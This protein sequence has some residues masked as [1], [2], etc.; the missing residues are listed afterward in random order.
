MVR[1]VEHRS[2]IASVLHGARKSVGLS[3]EQASRDAGIPI[4]YARLLEGESGA[5]I[6]ISDSLY[7]IPFF[8]R[9]ANYLGL[10]AEDLLPDFLGEMQ[11]V[12][13]AMGRPAR[14][15]HRSPVALLWKP[16]TIAAAVALSVLLINRQAPERPVFEDEP[17]AG[18]EIPAQEALAGAEAG[19]DPQPAGTVPAAD[20]PSAPSTDVAGP[21]AAAAQ[22]DAAAASGLAEVSA[23]DPGVA[24]TLETG[25]GL[26]PPGHLDPAGPGPDPAPPPAGRELRIVASQEAWLAL[27]VDDEPA[28]G[29]LLRPGESRTWTARETF[30]L[31]LGNAGGVTV[32]LDGRTLPSLGK[33]GQVVRNLRLP[34]GAASLPSEG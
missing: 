5:G 2:R 22:P 8:R 23:P 6:G 9:Y 20:A 30:T 32:A 10:K 21:L 11:E 13:G 26:A 29:V 7:L 1:S 18:P 16:A 19:P 31:S 15:S 28:K 24:S 12:P 27:G 17:W 4:R 25:A 3:V 33:S 34:Q 14:A